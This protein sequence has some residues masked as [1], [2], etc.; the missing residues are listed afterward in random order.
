MASPPA[1]DL[2]LS[3]LLRRNAHQLRNRV[4]ALISVIDVVEAL[5][6]GGPELH[7]EALELL[8][9]ASV[10][11][12]QLA[13]GWTGEARS[14]Y[15]EQRSR[16]DAATLARDAEDELGVAVTLEADSADATR[17]DRR[18]LAALLERLATIGPRRAQ[19][20]ARE[21]HRIRFLTLE[22]ETAS[23]GGAAL[24]ASEPVRALLDRLGAQAWIEAELRL[25]V[26]MPVMIDAPPARAAI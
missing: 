8:T 11:L 24:L 14:L 4:T 18:I 20:A 9:E 22:V 23:S 26:Q 7:G 25:V 5:A 6:S 15:G 16:V 3:A 21:R 12:R 17:A 1:T 13:D 10:E 2:M 19:V